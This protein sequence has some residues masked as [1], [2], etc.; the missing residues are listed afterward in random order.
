MNN[1]K[2][3]HSLLVEGDEA[4][5]FIESLISLDPE[6]G[7]FKTSFLLKPDGKI[8]HWFVIQKLEKNL[9]IFQSK[10]QLEEIK[11]SLEFY[12]IRTKCTL[13]IVEDERY[14]KVKINKDTFNFL[15]TPDQENLLSWK[16]LAILLELPLPE[17]IEEGLL[18][19]ETKWLDIMV[20]FNKGCFLG[21]EQASRVKFRG[22]PRRLLTSKGDSQELIKISN[23]KM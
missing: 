9:N 23:A 7:T 5:E 15:E 2:I 6:E 19:N 20:D 1:I 22:R 4:I 14:I 18:P 8:G 11:T 10:E 3:T 21:Q 13:G 12:K 16:E 17:I